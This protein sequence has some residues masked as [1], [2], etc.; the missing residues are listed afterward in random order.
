LRRHRAHRGGYRVG[1]EVASLVAKLPDLEQR[2]EANPHRTRYS[3]AIPRL[4]RTRRERPAGEVA[5]VDARV[6]AQGRT[7]LQRVLR[8]RIVFTPSG[9]GYDFAA[10]TR[11]DKLF[12]GVASPRPSFIRRDDRTG[13]EDI[14]AITETEGDCGRLLE[15]IHGCNVCCRSLPNASASP[16]TARYTAAL[17]GAERNQ[18]NGGSDS[19]RTSTL[20]R[21]RSAYRNE[22]TSS[23]PNNTEA[24]AIATAVNQ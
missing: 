2:N 1:R 16:R 12:T 9:N 8:G 24:S 20:T 5:A 6:G 18:R 21:S 7:V 23:T 22:S 13:L 14:R 11:Y 15:R 3:P 10:P 4:P 17:N 19:S